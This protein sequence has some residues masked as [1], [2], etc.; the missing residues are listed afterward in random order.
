MAEE[1]AKKRALDFTNVKDGGQFNPVH[2][3]PGDYLMEVYAVTEGQSKNDNLTWTF[4][5]RLTDQPRATY[6]YRCALTENSLWKV[7]NLF[8]ACGIAVPKK[9]INVDPNKLVGKK[10]GAALEDDEYEGNIRSAIAAVFPA[11]DVQP[12]KKTKRA[13]EEDDEIV[14]EDEEIEEDVEDEIDIEDL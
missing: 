5:C 14:D 11:D 2:K 12:P 4:H 9:K 6:P 3:Q 10:F 13:Q 8:V 1:K 7:R